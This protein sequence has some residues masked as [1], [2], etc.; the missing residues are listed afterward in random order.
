MEITKSNSTL[1]DLYLRAIAMEY[2]RTKYCPNDNC[3]A[4]IG[5]RND[6]YVQCPKGHKF[7]FIC[8]NDWHDTEP[9]KRNINVEYEKWK[10]KRILKQ[11]PNCNYITEREK[12]DQDKDCVQCK[13]CKGY[14]CWKCVVISSFDHMNKQ[15]KC[16]R[17]KNTL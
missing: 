7:C 5:K 6:K 13:G 8:M 17:S 4:L 1:Y 12:K 3:N 11:C 16:L 14:W 9:C 15:S 2:S 10:P